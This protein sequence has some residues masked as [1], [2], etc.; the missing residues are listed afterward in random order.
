MPRK[1]L[2]AVVLTNAA[3]TTVAAYALAHSW[4]AA[5]AAGAFA[6]ILVRIGMAL[7]VAPQPLPV[8]RNDL[9]A[10]GLAGRPV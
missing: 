4:P 8:R 9:S 2:A 3:A 5:L 10:R 6:A 7:S 1:T